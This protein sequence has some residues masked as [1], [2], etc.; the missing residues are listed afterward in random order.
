MWSHM[1]ASQNMEYL[2]DFPKRVASSSP[3]AIDNWLIKWLNLKIILV[4]GAFLIMIC[5]SDHD[6]QTLKNNYPDNIKNNNN[7]TQ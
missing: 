4:E 2:I 3:T 5:L 6:S 1:L 7:F